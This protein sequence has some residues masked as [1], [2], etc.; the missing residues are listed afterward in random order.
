LINANPLVKL[1]QHL[2]LQVHDR[3]RTKTPSEENCQRPKHKQSV[4][5]RIPQHHHPMKKTLRYT[6]PLYLNICKTYSFLEHEKLWKN[7][8]SFNIQGY[9]PS[10]IREPVSVKVWMNKLL[11]TITRRLLK[12]IINYIIQELTIPNK[13]HGTRI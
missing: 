4:K 8:N 3:K 12:R 9:S 11:K 5:Y 1:T 7:S 6:Y 10:N 2:F 13:M